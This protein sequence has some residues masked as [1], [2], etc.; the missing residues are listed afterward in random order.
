MS[1]SWR[2]AGLFRRGAW[3][4]SLVVSIHPWTN[5]ELVAQLRR[6]ASV[7]PVA[8]T[9][10]G[11]LLIGAGAAYA[12]G[13][14][15]PLSGLEG[16]LLAIGRLSFAYGLADRILVEVRG[17]VRQVL[18]VERR[19][20]SE[21]ELEEGVDDGTTSDVGDFRIGFTLAPLGSRRG[22]SGGARVEVKLPNSDERKGIGTNTTDVRLSLLGSYGFERLRFTADLGIG[23]LEAPVE[24]FEQNDVLVYAAELLYGPG[25]GSWRL[26]LAVDGRASTRDRVPVGTEDL[27][28]VRS[29][30]ELRAGAWLLDL[31]GAIGYAEASPEWAVRGGISYRPNPAGPGRREHHGRDRDG[32]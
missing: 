19:G 12:G 24:G 26:A 2:R 31:E 29:G 10:R 18:Y 32:R 1:S 22:A 11:D 4:A 17:D 16:D 8:E 15:F 14:A 25:G 28:E 9:R 5:A 27:G 21:V 20:D 13:V 23:I 30:L 3:V 6:D 7:Q